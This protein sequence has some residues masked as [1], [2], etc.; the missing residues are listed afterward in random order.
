MCRAV[1][2]LLSVAGTPAIHRIGEGRRRCRTKCPGQVP[3]LD[4]LTEMIQ[5][6]PAN[7]R[8]GSADSFRA[9]QVLP[10]VEVRVAR[11][12]VSSVSPA[13]SYAMT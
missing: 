4:R 8:K 12:A 13:G 7:G 2:G 10:R 11:L 3:K 6:R 9:A 1:L 5:S